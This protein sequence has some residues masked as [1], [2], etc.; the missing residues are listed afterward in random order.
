MS[1]PWAM[2]RARA[3][4]FLPSGRKD[5]VAAEC[6]GFERFLDLDYEHGLAEWVDGEVRLYKSNTSEHQTIV[7][8]LN[9]LIGMY[10]DARG[11]G[12]VKS[13]PYA[14]RVSPGGS[15]REPDLMFVLAANRDRVCSRY[16]DGPPDL[17]IEVVSED[18]VGRDRAEKF[19]EYESAGIPEYWIIDSR[20]NRRR[21][22]FFVLQD[23][24]YRPAAVGDDGVYRS[25]V[26]TG[27]WLRLEWLWQE[28]PAAF[29]ALQEIIASVQPADA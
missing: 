28:E 7:D 16:L 15:G 5:Y 12:T 17:V 25:T 1:Y 6:M 23:G 26:I 2:S 4:A 27:F 14:M 29:A 9:R 3:V 21:A 19:G 8:L 20:P 24:A 22:E 10:A 11:P 13:A 18:S